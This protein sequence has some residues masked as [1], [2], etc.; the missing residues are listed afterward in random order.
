[1]IKSH[2]RVTDRNGRRLAILPAHG[3]TPKAHERAIG[4][5]KRAATAAFGPDCYTFVH[6][7]EGPGIGGISYQTHSNPLAYNNRRQNPHG[8]S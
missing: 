5:A 1:M 6:D 4:C 8:R 7:D 2:V 3:K